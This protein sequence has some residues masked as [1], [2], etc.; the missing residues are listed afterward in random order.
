VNHERLP[1]AGRARLGSRG[2][3]RA[4]RTGPKDDQED[5]EWRESHTSCS[6]EV[7]CLSLQRWV[8]TGRSPSKKGVYARSDELCRTLPK[9]RQTPFHGG[10]GMHS[11][12]GLSPKLT[13]ERFWHGPVS[14]PV[15]G[16]VL[17]RLDP[18]F[19]GFCGFH[20]AA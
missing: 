12:F 5:T 6:Q 3:I 20:G 2:P 7:G 15:F 13:L 17:C 18:F 11:L 16:P 9:P 19:A 14:G 1:V 10:N 4:P 8:S